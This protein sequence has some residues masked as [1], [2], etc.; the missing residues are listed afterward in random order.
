MGIP[1]MKYITKKYPDTTFAASYCKTLISDKVDSG[2]QGIFDQKCKNC[3]AGL[4]H[5][6]Q[7][8]AKPT[9]TRNAKP[10]YDNLFKQNTRHEN[11]P[12]IPLKSQRS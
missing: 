2:R 7:R 1:Y 10:H 6:K 9:E 3:S 4:T 11:L 8:I 12:G 5:E